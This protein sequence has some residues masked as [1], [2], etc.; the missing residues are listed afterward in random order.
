MS[1][2]NLSFVACCW[3]P[4]HKSRLLPKDWLGLRRRHARIPISG[5]SSQTAGVTNSV[6]GVE[7]LSRFDSTKVEVNAYI[8]KEIT[9]QT[10]L[11]SFA[12]NNLLLF[13]N[14]EL[15]D[16]GFNE[17]GPIDLL[18]GAD[19]AWNILREGRRV[20]SKGNLVAHNTVFG[21]VITVSLHVGVNED[22]DVLLRSFWEIEGVPHHLSMGRD[23]DF[24]ESNFSQTCSRAPDNK[25]IVEL[26][27]RQSEVR[28][29]N[30]LSGALSR[31]SAMERRFA[32]NESLRI[33]NL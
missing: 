5:I 33:A 13:E 25:Y 2:E 18:L 20:D 6:V 8:L 22:V 23:E 31:L 9:S 24:A 1:Q 12:V 10:P 3:I 15:A 19:T 16:P 27:F 17:S 29:G 4:G 7:L 21:W 11:F 28:F 30:T 26:P 14:L 32:H